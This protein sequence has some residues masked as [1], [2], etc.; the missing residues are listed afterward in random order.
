MSLQ[1]HL[2]ILVQSHVHIY[3]LFYLGRVSTFHTC[4]DGVG[5]RDEVKEEEAEWVG[6]NGG[7]MRVGEEKESLLTLPTGLALALETGN[8]PHSILMYST[9]K[10]TSTL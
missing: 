7:V 1:Q 3:C 5:T 9:C 8:I 2:R 10:K 4:W 6:E